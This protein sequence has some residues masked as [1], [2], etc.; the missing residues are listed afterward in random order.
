MAKRGKRVP[1]VGR[2]SP[3]TRPSVRRGSG[4][5]AGAGL[6]AWALRPA[7][8]GHRG[9]CHLAAAG[10]GRAGAGCAVA[11]GGGLRVVHGGSPGWLDDGCHRWQDFR[12]DASYPTGDCD[13]PSARVPERS[14]RSTEWH[15]AH[16]GAEPSRRVCIASTPPRATFSCARSTRAARA[17]A[18][19]RTRARCCPWPG[20]PP[21]ARGSA[22]PCRRPR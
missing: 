21:T 6:A 13:E 18:A 16:P 14:W 12:R 2:P 19:R 5:G 10:A 7:C 22:A 8:A 9:G 1:A 3:P 20:T 17:C 15:G 4:P 11:G